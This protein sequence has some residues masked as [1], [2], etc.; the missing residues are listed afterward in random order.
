[1]T[2]RMTPIL[3]LVLVLAACSS[4]G[5]AE[6][7][8]PGDPED[9]HPYEGI[10]PGETVHFTGTEPFWGGQ[11]AGG[12]LTY[13]TPDKP[14]GETIRIARFAGR[15]G[16]SFTGKMADGKPFGMAVTPGECSDGMSDRTYPFTVTLRIGPQGEGQLR[17][18]CA[19]TASRPYAGPENP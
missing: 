3:P 13:T 16:I 14:A 10:A 6:T 18:G 1:M 11:A 8:A 7:N 17:T 2:L 19:W 15:N 12:V 4:G 9:R 5:P